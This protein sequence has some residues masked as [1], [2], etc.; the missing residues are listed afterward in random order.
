MPKSVKKN[1]TKT[2]ANVTWRGARYAIPFDV[3]KKYKVTANKDGAGSKDFVFGE[4]ISEFGEPAV[5]LKGLRT[6]ENLSQVVFAKTIDVTQANLSAM[7][8][9]RRPI[10]KTIAKRIANKFEVDYRLFL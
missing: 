6:K 2:L 10:G 5:L 3:L 9:G 7:E 1:Q 8:N 4:L